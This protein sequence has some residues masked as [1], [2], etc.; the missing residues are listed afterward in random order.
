MAQKVSREG[1]IEIAAHEGIVTSP[2]KD[3]VGVWTFGIG[4]T[5]GAG[6]PHPAKMK[7][8]VA[9][10]ISTI[11]KLFETDVTKFEKRVRAAFT[12]KLTQKQF[13]AAVSFDFN[14]GSIHKATWV[15]LFN[16]GDVAGAK[17]A[18][19]NWRKPAEIIPR[20]KKERDL[21][22]KG[23]YSSNGQANV[24]PA[25]T[26]GRVQWSSGKRAN[27]ARL[28]DMAE[29]H[30]PAQPDKPVSAPTTPTDK[31]NAPEATKGGVLVILIRAVL[32][33]LGLK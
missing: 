16:A 32:K 31:P 13:D 24:Y 18:F 22:F 27:V 1:L 30:A 29:P 33:I 19:M 21:F 23:K 4:H 2:Y 10:P 17:E 25:S 15:K 26:S 7:K 14:T 28:M 20:R 9:Q 12:V 11:M 5:A 8:G 6:A 3:S